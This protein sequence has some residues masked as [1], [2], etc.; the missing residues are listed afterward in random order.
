MKICFGSIG[1]EGRLDTVASTTNTV[2]APP[3]DRVVALGLHADRGAGSLAEY[4][5]RARIAGQACERGYDALK[6]GQQ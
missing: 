3:C 1:G 2:P 5:D 6:P 4:A